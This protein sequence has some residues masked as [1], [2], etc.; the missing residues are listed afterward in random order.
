MR[1]ICDCKTKFVLP[2]DAGYFMMF[3]ATPRLVTIIKYFGLV[4]LTIENILTRKNYKL[5]VILYKNDCKWKD[6]LSILQSKKGYL[7]TGEGCAHTCPGVT[8]QS[9]RK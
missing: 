3:T 8:G 6:F 2:P 5:C 4:N 7:I 1:S 9:A